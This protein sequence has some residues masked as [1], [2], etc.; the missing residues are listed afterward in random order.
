MF[1]ASLVR[2]VGSAAKFFCVSYGQTQWTF[3]GRALPL[4]AFVTEQPRTMNT[5]LG[6]INAQLEN[7]GYY[8]C[9]GSYKDGS[10]FYKSGFLAVTGKLLIMQ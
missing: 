10:E 4:N 5:L 6:I 1:P 3:E 9:K 2:S 7:S 8:T